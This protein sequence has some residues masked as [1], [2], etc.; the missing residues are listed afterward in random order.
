M[1]Q[2]WGQKRVWKASLLPE[3]TRVALE[4][5]AKLCDLTLIVLGPAVMK[6]RLVLAAK[7]LSLRAAWGCLLGQTQL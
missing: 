5:L 6:D 3:L 7:Q 2:L 1:L 4:Q